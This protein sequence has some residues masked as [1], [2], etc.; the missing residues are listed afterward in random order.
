MARQKLSADEI[1]KNLQNLKDW[2]L[3]G[4][5]ITKRFEFANFAESLDF[6][7]KVGVLAEK[8][9]HHPDIKFGW[10]YAEFEITTHDAG[11][12]TERDFNLAKEV[13]GLN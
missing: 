6:V 7:N 3:D 13:D 5:K 10:G 12:L 2:K 1:E 9:D 8:A 11:G 4:V